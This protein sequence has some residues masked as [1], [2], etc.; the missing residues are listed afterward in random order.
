MKYLRSDFSFGTSLVVN[1]FTDVDVLVHAHAE[2]SVIVLDSIS[3]ENGLQLVD[4]VD[5]ATRES[6]ERM[7][8]EVHGRMK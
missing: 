2:G 3:T 1:D 5:D 8:R 4:K 6:I 7:A